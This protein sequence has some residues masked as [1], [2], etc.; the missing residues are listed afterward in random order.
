MPTDLS[1]PSRDV[2]LV[3]PRFIEVVNSALNAC[4]VAGHKIEVF[5][6][7]RSPQ[8]Q[9]WL[10]E[11]GRKR[12]GNIVTKA[13]PWQSWHQYGLAVDVAAKDAQGRWTWSYD[14][15]AVAAILVAH[16][17]EH[18]GPA[19]LG[20]FQWSGGLR[21]DQASSLTKEAGV[22][23]LWQEVFSAVVKKKQGLS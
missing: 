23:R 5:E 6:A 15:K 12:A 4:H 1:I 16:G 13:G 21:I 8:R 17:L 14:T 20:H 10:Y 7:F 9:G 18:G 11:Q 22:Q 19:D 3:Y 2:S